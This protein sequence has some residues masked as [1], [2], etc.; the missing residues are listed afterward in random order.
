MGD[1]SVFASR[2]AFVHTAVVD[3]RNAEGEFG[4]TSYRL[5]TTVPPRDGAGSYAES[6]PMSVSG[7]Y[8]VFDTAHAAQA[9]SLDGIAEEIAT[10]MPRGGILRSYFMPRETPRSFGEA[11]YGYA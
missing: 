4:A 1:G 5:T 3:P 7:Y 2:D 11:T 9:A 10:S 8:P 6:V